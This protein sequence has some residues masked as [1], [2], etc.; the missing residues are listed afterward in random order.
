MICLHN[1]TTSL[2]LSTFLATQRHARGRKHFHLFCILVHYLDHN[3]YCD[4]CH[5]HS[6]HNYN[7]FTFWVINLQLHHYH[8]HEHFHFLGINLQLHH[9]HN[10][11][12]HHHKH[13]HFFWDNLVF[14]SLPPSWFSGPSAKWSTES[15]DIL[16]PR[17]YL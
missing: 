5:H 7:T 2:S 16:S 8:H 1:L 13:F 15:P 6:H 14:R 9:Y 4:C 12:Y 3:C 17:Y 10:H 11:H